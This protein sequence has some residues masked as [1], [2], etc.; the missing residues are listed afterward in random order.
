MLG[1]WLDAKC[2]KCLPE[3]GKCLGIFFS[4][5]NL[6]SYCVSMCFPFNI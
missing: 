5:I 2:I 4:G 1:E 6:K 3:V